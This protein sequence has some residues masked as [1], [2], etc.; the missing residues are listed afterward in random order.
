MTTIEEARRSLA[1]PTSPCH[2]CPMRRDAIKGWLGGN[3]PQE[4]LAYCHSDEAYPCHTSIGPGCA[5]MAIYR[6]NVG[7]RP[8]DP[9][10]LRLPADRERVF[11][12][13]MEF[14]EHHT[15][16]KKKPNAKKQRRAI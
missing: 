10:A 13:P 7:K 6:A 12:T 16:K 8:R 14:L 3:T 9:K 4:F 15:I 11:A 2:D 1:Q 5:G